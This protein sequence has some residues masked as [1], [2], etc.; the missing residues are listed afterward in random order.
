MNERVKKIVSQVRLYLKEIGTD[1]I[2]NKEIYNKA[3]YI[4]DEILRETKCKQIEFDI[5][6]INNV[7]EYDIQL[8]DV[9]LIKTHDTSWGDVLTYKSFSVWNEYSNTGNNY[10]VYFSLFDHKIYLKPLPLRDDDWIKIYAYQE[11]V[12]IPMDDDIEPEVPTYADRCLIFGICAEFKPEKYY[13]MYEQA[14]SKVA[15][16]AHNRIS[17]PKESEL[18]W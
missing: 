13:D 6:T 18:N 10:P 8:E 9:S 4:Q 15:M 17:R 1:V 14:K 16:N 11:S 5:Y 12:I 2:Q 7:G 3:N